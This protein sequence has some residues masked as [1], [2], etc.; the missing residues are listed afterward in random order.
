VTIKPGNNGEFTVLADG[1]KLW[2]KFETHR[3]PKPSEITDQLMSAL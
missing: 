1:D 3:F 2:D